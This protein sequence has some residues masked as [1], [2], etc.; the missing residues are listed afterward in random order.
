MGGARQVAVSGAGKEATERSEQPQEQKKEKEI[1]IE[2]EM[3]EEKE[4]VSQQWD[5][6]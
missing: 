5:T 3:E 6:C 2:M 4:K 1:E